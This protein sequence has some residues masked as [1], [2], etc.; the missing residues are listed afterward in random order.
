MKGIINLYENNNI[1]SYNTIKNLKNFFKSHKIEE[2]WYN[3]SNILLV[4]S[5]LKNQS[6]I[7]FIYNEII[8][9]FFPDNY[10]EY[11]LGSPCY[12]T[13]I[14]SNQPYIFHKRR[15][16]YKNTIMLIKTNKTRF[17]G[18]TDLSWGGRENAG[19]ENY[20]NTKTKLFNLDNKKIF[21]YNKNQ[22]NLRYIRPIM[23]DNNYIASFGFNDIYLDCL[24][25][26]SSSNFP[27]LFICD[28]ENKD[29]NY[30]LNEKIKYIRLITIY[31]CFITW[32]S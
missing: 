2:F 14:D 9:P 24:P 20:E 11:I 29:F 5:I 27:M 3:F 1:S 32:T 21:K 22:E 8:R 17:G 31:G 16:K 26:E 15:D 10:D 12:K 25:W 4:S 30:L 28:D 19:D 13:S 18:I 7:D 6:D 23:G